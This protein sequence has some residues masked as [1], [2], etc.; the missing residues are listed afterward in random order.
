MPDREGVIALLLS[1]DGMADHLSR[2]TE[3]GQSMQFEVRGHDAVNVERHAV[4]RHSL[5]R[6]RECPAVCS[7][8][9]GVD[10]TLIPDF[11][12]FRLGE[13]GVPPIGQVR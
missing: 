3:L 12:A 4:S 11:D 6:L 2:T 7:L 1:L 8:L 13:H 9:I 10:K 5:E